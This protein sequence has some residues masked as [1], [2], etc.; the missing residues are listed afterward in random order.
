MLKFLVFS[1]QSDHSHCLPKSW[2][3]VV[4]AK[5]VPVG[6]DL[7][8]LSKAEYLKYKGGQEKTI[9]YLRGCNCQPRQRIEMRPRPVSEETDGGR[10]RLGREIH[11]LTNAFQ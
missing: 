1:E 4:F 10:V 5:S 8:F 9:V 3:L 11:V 7:F 2:V 6:L